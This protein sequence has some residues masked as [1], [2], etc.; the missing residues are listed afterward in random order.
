MEVEYARTKWGLFISD[1]ESE[2]LDYFL[3]HGGFKTNINYY[4]RH[5]VIESLLTKFMDVLPEKHFLYYLKDAKPSYPTDENS[6]KLIKALITGPITSQDPATYT[7]TVI[8]KKHEFCLSALFKTKFYTD[9]LF[10]RSFSVLPVRVTVRF[11]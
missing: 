3:L 1:V 4:N 10:S 2:Y 6:I 5:Q 9:P 11:W 7:A 8:S